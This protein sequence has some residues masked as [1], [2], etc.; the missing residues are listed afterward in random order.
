MLTLFHV[1]MSHA[2]E[3]ILI[4]SESYMYTK[5]IIR[6]FQIYVHDVE[7]VIDYINVFCNHCP[8]EEIIVRIYVVLY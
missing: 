7:Y 8:R 1:Y 6:F 5:D 4:V 2:Y 3:Y